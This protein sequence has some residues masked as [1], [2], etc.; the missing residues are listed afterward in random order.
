VDAG[1]I[2][3]GRRAP[4]KWGR[5][6]AKRALLAWNRCDKEE[7]EEEEER[8]RNE[9]KA[10]TVYLTVTLISLPSLPAP[11]RDVLA[12]LRCQPAT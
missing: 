3:G 12:M 2:G 8:R 5:G 1:V 9:G 6:K 11:A 10:M 7:E 4:V